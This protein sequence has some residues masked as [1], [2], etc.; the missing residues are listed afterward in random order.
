MGQ[1]EGVESVWTH[2]VGWQASSWHGQQTAGSWFRPETL[3]ATLGD[4]HRGH[5]PRDGMELVVE[6][7]EAQG[8]N[9][10]RSRPKP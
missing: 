10:H 2:L 1:E 7:V 5:L 6:W 9:K 3:M 4:Q 8:E